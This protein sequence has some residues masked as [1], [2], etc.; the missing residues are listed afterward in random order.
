MDQG[1]ASELR[2]AGVKVLPRLT[3]IGADG[4]WFDKGLGAFLRNA[5]SAAALRERLLAALAASGA[6]GVNIDVE[7]IQPE[8]KSAYVDWLSRLTEALHARKLSV[9]VDVPMSNKAFDYEAIGRIADAVVLMAYDQHWSTSGPGPIASRPW[10]ENGVDQAIQ[11]ISADKL[12]VGVGAYAFDW[13]EGVAAAEA[14]TN[15]EAL[16]LA[17]RH[18]AN[19]EAG[20]QDVNSHFHYVDEDGLNHD[21]WML[22]AV[23]AWNQ[24]LYARR[25]GLRGAALWRTGVEEPQLWSFFGA[26]AS[27][28]FDPR[29]LSRMP[30]P[31]TVRLEGEGEL[32]RVRESVHSGERSLVVTND[33]IDSAVYET[34]PGSF[35]VQ[36]F[37][38]RTDKKIAFTFDD[39]PDPT[40]TPQV[41]SVLAKYHAPA[42]FFLI[43]ENV[44]RFPELARAEVEAGH[45]VGNHT[46]SHPDLRTIS[47]QRLWAELTATQR[48]IEAATGRSTLLFRP[49]YDTDSAPTTAA[50]LSPLED[51]DQMGYV[52]VG[53]DVDPEDYDQPGAAAI[54][55]TVMDGLAAGDGRIVLFH[56]AGGVRSQTVEAL[57]RLI[58]AL[59]DAG[60]EIA[61]LSDVL[62]VP[63]ATLNP[64]VTQREGVLSTGAR[65]MSWASTYGSGVL[66]VS[67]AVMTTVAILRI[68][69]LGVLVARQ[70][71]RK[72]SE[73]PSDFEPPVCLLVPAFNEELVIGRTIEAA[74][75]SDYKSMRNPGHRRRQ[76]GWYGRRGRSLG[77]A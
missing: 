62:G 2:A 76:H 35:K 47:K 5:R 67:F 72:T 30:P 63:A 50:Q 58:P 25:S 65:I 69:F 57:D 7:N 70:S 53:A 23:S 36:R 32:L 29:R 3:N 17:A 34:L 19:V 18:D 31:E 46:Y 43:G 49:P 45:L 42:T 15:D 52:V 59:R 77:G 28:E 22:D 44:Q 51:V 33:F 13:T 68:L 6:D 8:D 1:L 20:E 38:D 26:G 12:I 60:Y 24:Y 64:E 55:K 39:G 27:A 48:Q 10:F 56:D 4:E 21:V 74:L 54:F 71:R 37:G 66:V 14:L 40:W 41:L 75:A 16:G 11:R 9:T 73:Q 61:P